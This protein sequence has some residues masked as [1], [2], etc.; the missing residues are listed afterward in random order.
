MSA[1]TLYLSGLVTNVRSFLLNPQNKDE[2]KQQ[3]ISKKV[4]LT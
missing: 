3:L 4:K 2:V 1:E